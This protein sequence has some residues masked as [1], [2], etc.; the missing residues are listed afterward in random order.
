[1]IV[2]TP[3]VTIVGIVDRGISGKERLHLSAVANVNLNYYVI[4]DTVYVG[5]D[6]I[7]PIP[8]RAYWF[9]DYQVRAGDHIILYTKPGEQSKKQRSDGYT[10]HFFYWGLD[11]TLWKDP[12]SCAVLLEV[13][14]WETSQRG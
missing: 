6:A 11:R 7:A 1:M 14:N 13:S 2:K 12:S 4:F 10:N 5:N 8:R 3:T 9:S